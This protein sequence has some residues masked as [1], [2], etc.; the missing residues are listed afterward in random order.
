[1]S[2]D[3]D[4][5]KSEASRQ[6]HQRAIWGRSGLNSSQHGPDSQPQLQQ[7]DKP[8]NAWPDDE[9]LDEAPQ[10]LEE[11]GYDEQVEEPPPTQSKLMQR[12]WQYLS[13]VLVPLLF[14]AVTCLIV[15]PLIATGH[16]SL[17]R[18]GFWPVIL[19]IIAVALAQGVALYSSGTNNSLWVVSNI[20]AFFLFLLVGTFAIFGLLP[21]LILFILLLAVSLILARLYITPVPEGFVDI[22]Y[23]FGKY[24]RTLYPGFNMILPWEKVVHEL[25]TTEVQWDCPPQRVQMS[26]TE[27]VVL[28]M[29]ISYQLLPTVAYLAVTQVKQWEE[30]VH[31][32]CIAAI[33]TIVTTFSPDD[34]IVWQHGLHSQ[35]GHL[36]NPHSKP[37]QIARWEQINSYL[38]DHIRDRVTPWGV[39]LNWVRIHDI[40]LTPHGAPILGESTAP[41]DAGATSPMPTEVARQAQ[42]A[43]AVPPRPGPAA[44]PDAGPNVSQAAPGAYAAGAA[45]A[46]PPPRARVFTLPKTLRDEDLEKVLVKAYK[47][48]REGRITDPETIRSIADT[49][50]SVAQD[51]EKSKL[52]SFDIERAV[53]NLHKQADRYEELYT[54]NSIYS[55]DTRP[56]WP[57]RRAS[58][59]NLMAGG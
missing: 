9:A 47:E 49:F 39:Q 31:N 30:S 5:Q 27:D 19:V 41:A 53:H 46:S 8:T 57:M 12:V 10:P 21:G 29:M 59:E 4:K 51:P 34:L 38:F 44:R 24:S 48:V 26:R 33:Q 17:P 56:D 1:M 2:S 25:S 36:S 14:G 20:G 15:L 43:G 58:D 23:A 22:V 45:S 16:A 3:S 18:I 6:G 37:D 28:R 54:V 7:R 52:V 32:V 50:L 11:E 35:A 55:D 42:S 13:T 40:I